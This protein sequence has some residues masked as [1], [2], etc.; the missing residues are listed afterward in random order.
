M[1]DRREVSLGGGRAVIFACRIDTLSDIVSLYLIQCFKGRLTSGVTHTPVGRPAFTSCPRS[2]PNPALLSAHARTNASCLMPTPACGLAMS[3][4]FGNAA[5][6]GP[7]KPCAA[8]SNEALIPSV[9]E[10]WSAVGGRKVSDWAS[11]RVRT[12]EEGSS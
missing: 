7:E 2:R 1:L 11:N 10:R 6:T 8:A 12:E 4:A 5:C 9:G 3:D